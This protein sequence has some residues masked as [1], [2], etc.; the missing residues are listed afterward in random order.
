MA[1][2]SDQSESKGMAFPVFPQGVKVI[3]QSTKK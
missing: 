2:P 3:K 1:I